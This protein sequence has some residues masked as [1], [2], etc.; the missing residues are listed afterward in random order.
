M[1]FLEAP[2]SKDIFGFRGPTQAIDLLD[3]SVPGPDMFI[4]NFAFEA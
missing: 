4:I 2:H 3:E 1:T